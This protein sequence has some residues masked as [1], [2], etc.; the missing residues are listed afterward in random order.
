MCARPSL[1]QQRWLGVR[2]AQRVRTAQAARPPIDARGALSETCLRQHA[3][4]WHTPGRPS[5]A[6]IG[7]TRGM[8]RHRKEGAVL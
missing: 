4:P 5:H 3:D 8:L 2:V 1:A 6:S 7:A